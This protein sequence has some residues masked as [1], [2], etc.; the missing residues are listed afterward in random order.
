MKILYFH[1]HFMTPKGSGGTRSYEFSRALIARGHSVTMI[2][3]SF[4]GGDTGLTGEYKNG[5]RQGTVDGIKVIEFYLPYSNHTEF[6]GRIL[7]FVK[8]AFKSVVTVFR[9]DYD[10]L[11]ASSTP[12]TAGI[13]GIFARWIRRKPFVFEVRDLWPE[14]PVEMGVIRNPILICCLKALEWSSYHSAIRCIGLSVGIVNGIVK[15]GIQAEKVDLIPNGCDIA[16]FQSP[17]LAAWRPEGVNPSDLLAVFTGTHGPANGLDAV[18]DAAAALKRRGVERGIKIAL[19]GDGRNKADLM[20]RAK[21]EGLTDIVLFL[22]PISKLQMT[23]LMKGADLGLQVLSNVPAFYFGTSP[24]KFF[25]YL[26]AGR[27]VLC[28][29]PGWVSNLILENRCGFVCNP[30]D[31]E[32]FADQLLVAKE[33]PKDLVEMGKRSL[34]LA[35][36]DFD[37]TK[38]AERWIESLIKAFDEWTN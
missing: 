3:G 11:F 23:G 5:E 13:P 36:R 30:D 16:L 22:D 33:N 29:Y 27:P 21:R 34:N 31:P 28:N 37:R 2:C 15:R 19:V 4:K 38:L 9:E 20:R 8:Y 24:N 18:L 17:A 25:D 26:S 12:L 6:L 7:V 14:L 32:S 1:Q 10:L 35:K